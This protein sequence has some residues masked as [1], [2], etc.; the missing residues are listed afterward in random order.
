MN[1]K[2]RKVKGFDG[3]HKVEHEHRR[4]LGIITMQNNE[5]RARR[6]YSTLHRM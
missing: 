3:M 5:I 2:V 1:T 4:L 6:Q